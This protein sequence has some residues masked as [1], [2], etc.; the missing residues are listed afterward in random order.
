ME[1]DE[2]DQKYF[3]RL[4][5]ELPQDDPSRSSLYKDLAKLAFQR[6]EYDKTL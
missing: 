3:D 6:R 4:L 2:L 5:K 1:K